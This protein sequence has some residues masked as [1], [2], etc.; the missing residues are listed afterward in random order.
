MRPPLSTPAGAAAA[1]AAA[2]ILV[3]LSPTRA[4]RTPTP[5]T[6]ANTGIAFLGFADGTGF[7]FGLA[8]PPAADS[9]PT[10][11]AQIVSP[12]N[13]AGAGWGGVAFGT[14]MIG[15]LQVVAWPSPS[16][17]NNNVMI[18]ARSS[19][20]RDIADTKPYTQNTISFAPIAKGTF[21]NG[22]HVSA[23]FVCTGCVASDS[24]AAAAAGRPAPF[25]YAYSLVAVSSPASKNSALSDHTTQ[26]EPY[27]GF[28]FTLADARTA[29]YK[30]FAALAVTASGE[31]DGGGGGGGGGNSTQP[32][33]GGSNSTG[34]ASNATGS[35]GS[36]AGSPA[37]PP[38]NDGDDDAGADAGAADSDDIV[39]HAAEDRLNYNKMP[40]GEVAALGVV[41]A[42]YVLH[43]FSVF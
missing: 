19:S 13:K 23:T 41:C 33:A 42:L 35:G 14:S 40:V 36:S 20:G 16:A 43:A 34:L 24:F 15:P 25:G 28:S 17:G 9:T 29:D 2:T 37:A 12:L 1:T 7:K 27:G 31:G 4:Q 3:L 22:T 11:I 32:T 39:V 21:A 8:L 10:L 18:A 26:G 5:Y 30:R 38:D 6:D